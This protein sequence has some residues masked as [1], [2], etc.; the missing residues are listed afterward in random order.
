MSV[1]ILY[2]SQQEL[3]TWQVAILMKTHEEEEAHSLLNN[4]NVN[5]GNNLLWALFKWHNLDLYI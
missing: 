2:D 3:W 1:Y 5:E 4:L